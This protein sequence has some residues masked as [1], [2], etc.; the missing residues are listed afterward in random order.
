MGNERKTEGKN[1]IVTLQRCS[2]L[3]KKLTQK[4]YLIRITVI[5]KNFIFTPAVLY[6]NCNMLIYYTYTEF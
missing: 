3:K 1:Y 5:L 6:S 4:M 2:K